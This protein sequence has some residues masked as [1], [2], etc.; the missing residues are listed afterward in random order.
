MKKVRFGIIGAGGIADRRTLP[1]MML[2]KNVEVTAVMEVNTELAE[3]LRVKYSAKYA[4]TDAEELVKNPEIDAVYIASPV[5][6]HCK[7]AMLAADYGKHILIEKPISMDIEEGEKLLEYCENKGVKVAAGFMMRFGAHVMNMKK[8]VEEGKIG[9]IVSGYSQFTLWLPQDAG[10]WRLVKAKSGG[11]SLMDMGVHCIDLI[12]YITRSRVV[13]VGAF[14]DTV[15]FDYDVEDSSTVILKLDNGAQCVVQTNFN[16][17]DEVAK[18]RLEFFGTKGRLMGS[19]VIGQNDGG[20]LTGIFMNNVPG[21]DAKQDHVDAKGVEIEGDFGNMYTR[22]VESFADS[23]L[24]DKPLVVPAT[25][26]LHV[27]K[28]IAAAY[29]SSKERKLI[30]M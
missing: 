6:F 1:G 26:A 10:N 19:N 17:P 3:R 29:R 13:E 14:N 16:I 2:A 12:E 7:Q 5:V 15:V 8:A 4:Y 22:E 18:W 20:T 11:G 21:Y 28:V 30:K 23:I 27:Q 9:Q 24:N 25:D